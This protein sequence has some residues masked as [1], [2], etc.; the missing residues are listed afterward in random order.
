MMALP[1]DVS[2]S[3]DVTVCPDAAEVVLASGSGSLGEDD[4][5]LAFCSLRQ[6]HSAI[7][8]I[9]RPRTPPPLL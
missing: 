2:A 7:R 3:S 4:D 8:A 6:G 5:V 1:W 9:G